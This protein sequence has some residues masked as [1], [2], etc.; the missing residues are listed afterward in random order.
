MFEHSWLILVGVKSKPFFKGHLPNIGSS[1][2]FRTS[3]DLSTG[4]FLSWSVMKPFRSTS[5][6]VKS[7]ATLPAAVESCQWTNLY[8]ETMGNPAQLHYF[9]NSILPMWGSVTANHSANLRHLATCL[10]WQPMSLDD[11]RVCACD[12][13]GAGSIIE[14]TSSNSSH[15]STSPSVSIICGISE[16]KIDRFILWKDMETRWKSDQKCR[17]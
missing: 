11:T 14:L 6:S 1:Q 17:I 10:T 12:T 4:E 13:H 5:K 3:R 8:R 16:T 2:S 9:L 7:A 15:L